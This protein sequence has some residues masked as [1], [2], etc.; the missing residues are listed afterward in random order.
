M[1]TNIVSLF[2]ENIKIIEVIVNLLLK[3]FIKVS[4]YWLN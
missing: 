4:K 3:K 1:Y 2:G